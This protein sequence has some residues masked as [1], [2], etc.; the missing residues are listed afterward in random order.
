MKD[1]KALWQYLAPYKGLAFKNVAFNLFSAFFALFTLVLIGPFL[2]ILFST[3]EVVPDPGPF[4]VKTHMI[5]DFFSYAGQYGQ[6]LFSNQI[7]LHGK[8]HTLLILILIVV[9]ASFL[10]N[11]FIFIANNAMASL[12][13]FT[14]RDFR[15]KIY[16][17]ILRLPLSYF[18]E[19]RKGD[20]MTR[21]SNDVGEIES[22]VMAS[23]SMILRDPITIILFVVY[24]FIASTRL[25]LFALVLLPISGW[26]I[27]RI[28]RKLRSRSLKGQQALGRLLSVLEETLTGLRVIK[29]FNGEEKMEAQF[30]AS[31]E[32]FAKLH[33]R[34]ARKQYLAHPVSEFLSTV[35][36][37]I[38]LYYGGL[39][40][41]NGTGKMSPEALIS[42]VA[43]FSQI[44]QPAKSI[45]LA[46]F[47]IQK[48]MASLERINFVLDADE[49][50]RDK[51]DAIAVTGFND[52]IEF[53]NVWFSYGQDPVLKDVSLKIMKGQTV[54]VVGR[55]GGG[56]STLVDLVPR[57]IDPA[58][59]QVLIDGVDIRDLKLKD[60][61]KLMGIVSQQAILFNDSFKNNIA[62]A[63]NEVVDEDVI[64]AASIANAHE[65]VLDSSEGYETLVGE[66][67]NKLSGGQRQ[68]ISIARAVMANPPILILDE[69]TS[70]LDTESERLVQD[71][72]E[73][74]MKNRTSIVIA[75]RLSTI[76]H[77]DMIV[78]VE[79]GR[80]VETGKH[81]ELLKISDGIYSK[82]YKMQSF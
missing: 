41:L 14:V 80:I 40:A 73:K 11:L 4:V 34:V 74:L 31:N 20:L 70:A 47:N 21:M 38:I 53:R 46:W 3:T 30:G 18:S 15:K 52:S 24:L 28:S 76:Q 22:S 50:I 72:M 60:L 81:E 67:G 63:V 78:V 44:I 1:L 51:D 56:K 66:G 27:G 8:V 58:G 71:A 35:V 69:A 57:F 54:A 42:F 77:A 10:K 62:F 43:V 65:F 16:E 55:S 45:T 13:A 7:E 32:K 23:L 25:T 39:L 59:G 17:K 49:T 2:K 19:A 29:G 61:R 79:D 9:I 64:K 5:S 36:M 68:R 6:F 12:R 37:L 33:R 82:L 48:G 75:H 26:A